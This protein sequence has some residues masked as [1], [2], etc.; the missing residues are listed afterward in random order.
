MRQWLGIAFFAMALGLVA[1]GDD[2]S[3]GSSE[4]VESATPQ[5]QIEDS[6]QTSPMGV[7]T[8]SFTD[9]R[10]GKTYK[11]VTIGKQTWMAENLNYA[12]G[13]IGQGDERYTWTEAQI[14]CP[15]GWHLPNE[16]EWDDLVDWMNE[17]YQPDSSEEK[18]PDWALKSTSGWENDTVDGKVIVGNGGN[19]VGLDLKPMGICEGSDCLHLG[20]IAAFWIQTFYPRDNIGE[21]FFFRI[22]IPAYSSGIERD[23]RMNVRCINDKHTVYESLNKCTPEREGAVANAG[24]EYY[25]CKDLGWVTPTLEEKLDFALGE[26]DST[27]ANKRFTLH[28]SVFMCAAWN[29]GSDYQWNYTPEDSAFIECATKG[30]TLCEVG[31][32]NGLR[33]ENVLYIIKNGYWKK[34]YVKDVLGYC[35]TARR[36][37][38]AKFRQKDYICRDDW[39]LAEAIELEHGICDESKLYDTLA[40]EGGDKVIC[41]DYR[42]RE[43]TRV[44]NELGFC[45]NDSAVGE[46]DGHKYIC[47]AKDHKWYYEMIDERDGQKYKAVWVEFEWDNNILVMAE[48]LKYGG[49][50]LYT[51][52][53]AQTACPDGWHV[54]SRNFTETLY[55]TFILNNDDMN[56]TLSLI[57]QSGWTFNGSNWSGLNLQPNAKDTVLAFSGPGYPPYQYDIYK[58]KSWFWLSDNEGSYAGILESIDDTEG[59]NYLFFETEKSD[60]PIEK[61]TVR[62]IKE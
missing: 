21:F 57:S 52:A 2:S 62:C 32:F 59:Q 45:F 36:G 30:D 25:K 12:D 27:N 15:D 31:E 53:E 28:D 55:E 10:D 49:D 11:T 4:Q 29:G 51:W 33:I 44:D 18:C 13:K 41:V 39:D 16:D 23:A 58:T 50:S 8:D 47:D 35:S 7:A 3:S 19:T 56:S 22:A 9:L 46:F 37:E 26:C 60:P 6:T 1:C 40:V 14:A 54:P 42:W 48:D 24:S 5:E 38:I 17:H 61:A 43:A 34:A 20:R